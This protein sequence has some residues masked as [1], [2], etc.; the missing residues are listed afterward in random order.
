MKTIKK[1]YSHFKRNKVSLLILLLIVVSF[2]LAYI[3]FQESKHSTVIRGFHPCF[4]VKSVD[5]TDETIK[6]KFKEIIPTKFYSNIKDFFGYETYAFDKI[7][8]FHNGTTEL[9]EIKEDTLKISI[10]LP[11]VQSYDGKL[12]CK[13]PT[14]KIPTLSHIK[15]II[16][17]SENDFSLKMSKNDFSISNYSQAKCYGKSFETRYCDFRNVAIYHGFLTFFANAEFNFPHPLMTIDGRSPPFSSQKSVLDQEP[18]VMSTSFHSISFTKRIEK[19]SIYMSIFNDSTTMW[20]TIASAS[21]PTIG[22]LDFFNI[23]FD[24][25]IIIRNGKNVN[26]VFKAVS[27][28]EVMFLDKYPKE[29]IFFKR[30]IVGLPTYEENP[31][32]LRET[33]QEKLVTFNFDKKLID[34]FKEKV[35][36]KFN[37]IKTQNDQLTVTLL[38]HNN[39]LQNIDDLEQYIR[40]NC[41]ICIFDRINFSSLSLERK[42]QISA[43]SDIFI[44]TESDF[45]SYSFWMQRNRFAPAIIEFQPYGI[46][47]T[48]IG[49]EIAKFSNFDYYSIQSINKIEIESPECSGL[50]QNY[51]TDECYNQYLNQNI[52]IELSEFSSVFDHVIRDRTNLV[53]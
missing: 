15:S 14:A 44:G 35:N 26:E 25:N 42:M 34:Q 7:L 22:C 17:Q 49:K 24:N 4:S 23:S 52:S 46:N 27:A 3:A 53:P 51:I 6:I 31:S 29:S 12:Y 41:D 30:L 1:K 36:S 37:L 48:R 8:N 38:E 33:D 18:V 50:K 13:T 2:I 21:L 40:T 32:Y 9:V 20:D 39:N 10:N 11:F 19:D 16:S 45:L 47:S 28:N 5:A 43:A